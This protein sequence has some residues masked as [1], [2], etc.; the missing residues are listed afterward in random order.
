MG[1]DDKTISEFDSKYLPGLENRGIRYYYYLNAGLGILNQFRNLFLGII[2]IY[3]TLELHSW[4]LLI[5]MF[6]PSVILLTIVG[7]YNTHRL[8]KVTEWLNIR[9]STHYARQQF[10]S[11][12]RQVALLEEIRDLLR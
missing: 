3:F 6:I 12:Q 5:A 2:A 9:F 8:A 4:W 11:I 1:L 10:D 7:W